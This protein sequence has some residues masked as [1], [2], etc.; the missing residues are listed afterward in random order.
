MSGDGPPTVDEYRLRL[1]IDF[2][3][4][5][6]KGTVGFDVP[7]GTASCRLDAEGLTIVG[8]KDGA[9]PLEP[10]SEPSGELRLERPTDGA[11]PISVDFEGRV[12][13]KNLF[14]LYRSRHGAG[15]VLT[16]HC[17]PT[18]ARKIFPC[19]DRPDRKARIALTVRAAPDL[20]VV[21]NTSP[22]AV[23]AVDGVREWTFAPTPPMSTYLFYL[24][25]GTFDRK[26]DRSR[27]V[28]LRVLTPPGRGEAGT[29]AAGAAGRILEA[30]ESYYGI[31]Y[32]LPKLDLIAI[33]EHAFGAMENWGA[34]S[35]QET[36]L[37]VD[38]AST[39]F[40]RRDVFE[41]AAHE[42]AHQWF[43]NLVTMAWWDDIWLN[44]SFA[45]LME[46]RISERIDPALDA[47]TDFI[48]R[49][50]GRAVAIDGDSLRSTHPVRVPVGSPDEVS[51]IFDEISYGK[52]SSVL[53]MLEGYLGEETFRRGVASY[54]ETFRYRNARTADLWASLATASGEPVAEIANPWIDRPGHP[55]VTARLGPGGLELSQR[56]FGFLGSTDEP[57]WPIPLLL[58]V[59]GERRRVRFSERTA[60]VPVPASATVHLN[61]GAVG[62][63][64]VRYDRT[65]YDRLL[66]GF[67]QRPGPDRW[68]VL[69]DLFAFL[70]SG[71]ADWPTYAAFVRA[72]FAAVDRLT[73]ETLT[74]SLVGLALTFPTVAEV[75]ELARTYLAAQ[76]ARLGLTRRPGEPPADGILRERV[77]F[78]RTRI[79]E[80]FA[81]EIAGRFADWDRL[82]PDLRAA[83]SAARARTGGTEGYRELRRA[84]EQAAV[85]SDA[86]RLAR[87]LAWTSDPALVRE[88]LDYAIGGRMNRSTIYP[89]LVQSALNPVSRAVLWPWLSERLGTLSDVFRGSGYLPLVLEAALPLLGLERER[90]IRAYFDAR[91]TP[92]G[93]RGIRKGLERITILRA[94]GR[95][96]PGG[97]GA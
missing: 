96:L 80:R 65:L 26:E 47:G 58:D 79:D 61:P 55:L 87:A 2:A 29:F 59:D 54:L 83:V 46:T 85:D 18:G 39:S 81:A 44:E 24:A 66:V 67:A 16:T 33:T 77:A 30:L 94:L 52:G 49:T 8:A 68:T 95:H 78:S 69:D 13:T 25:L 50:A 35:F 41:T 7:A 6:W 57:P 70:T 10:R 34:I 40:A 36:R 84:Q 88:T 76:L 31:P 12:E 15:Y 3:G 11:G 5:R 73:V 42:I 90:E 63:Y 53:A 23:R 74:S 75:Q 71:D 1:D 62:F 89:V 91:P 9:R 51:Q 32:P 45:S 43:G 97:P 37:L 4:L 56:R 64:R 48:L 22:T 17:E 82:D 38:G 20:E 19:F 21:A 60:S 28:A 93:D 14:G 92:E 27:R 86:L 72:S